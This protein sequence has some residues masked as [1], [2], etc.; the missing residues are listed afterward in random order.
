MR[1]ARWLGSRPR[2]DR[3]TVAA[4]KMAQRH[5]A[6]PVV[7]G[8]ARRVG[9]G[10]KNQA[11][12]KAVFTAYRDGKSIARPIKPDPAGREII[13]NLRPFPASERLIFLVPGCG[14]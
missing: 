8:E 7:H 11:D 3:S 2:E 9:H 13:G 5:R 6:G 14:G 4:E 12:L 10:G 1:G